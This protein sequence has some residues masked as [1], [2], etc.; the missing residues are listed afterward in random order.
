MLHGRMR[1]L[2]TRAERSLGWVD[3]PLHHP[4]G[5]QQYYP[6]GVVR[7]F[8]RESGQLWFPTFETSKEDIAAASPAPASY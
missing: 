2:L 8:T 1:S 7:N 6:R 5:L 3:R 4:R